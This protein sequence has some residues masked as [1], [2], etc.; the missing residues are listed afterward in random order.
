MAFLSENKKGLVRNRQAG[1]LFF[2]VLRNRQGQR[3]RCRTR[4]RRH[5]VAAVEGAE[6]H[7]AV[8]GV[9]G[10]FHLGTRN[11]NRTG[12]DERGHDAFHGQDSAHFPDLLKSLSHPVPAHPANQ[13]NVA[14]G[15]TIFI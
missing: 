14:P 9:A 3:L 10:Q 8:L 13:P 6:F 2:A 11:R 15:A 1:P 5:E 12:N 7:F 4:A